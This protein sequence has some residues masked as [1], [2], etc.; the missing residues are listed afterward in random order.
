M[1]EGAPEFPHQVVRSAALVRDGTGLIAHRVL[2]RI[3]QGIDLSKR[4]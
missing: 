3:A 1:R 4:G 2:L